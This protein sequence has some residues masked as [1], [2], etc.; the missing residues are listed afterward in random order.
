MAIINTTKVFNCMALILS[1]FASQA[2]ASSPAD[3][4]GFTIIKTFERATRT[5]RFHILPE[6]ELIGDLDRPTH[7]YPD[8]DFPNLM[9]FTPYNPN[10]GARNGEGIISCPLIM[11]FPGPVSKL[12]DS[13]IQQLKADKVQNTNVVVLFQDLPFHEA[14]Q[15]CFRPHG[16]VI[17]DAP[18]SQKGYDRKRQIRTGIFESEGGRVSFKGMPLNKTHM[19]HVHTH[20]ADG[21]NVF[22]PDNLHITGVDHLHPASF[23]TYTALREGKTT[24]AFVCLHMLMNDKQT[25]DLRASLSK[26][27]MKLVSENIHH[28]DKPSLLRCLTTTAQQPSFQGYNGLTRVL[29]MLTPA[30]PLLLDLA[31]PADQQPGARTLQ[32]IKRSLETKLTKAQLD[33]VPADFNPEVYLD[34]YWDVEFDAPRHE[35]DAFTFAVY[36]Y[37]M[38]GHSQGRI[39]ACQVSPNT[40]PKDFDSQRYLENY[41]DKLTGE[42][43]SFGIDD[44][45]LYAKLQYVNWGKGENRVYK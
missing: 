14:M 39:A 1:I 23:Y 3:T 37:A 40:A 5:N 38:W 15:L 18:A 19:D 30:A 22:S 41:W 31:G 9:F 24:K 8:A 11:R 28:S 17:P 27:D 35:M 32:D 6:N 20:A 10:E 4:E 42:A 13:I 21:G 43:K 36:Q 2:L 45:D 29:E 33:L 7:V 26:M 12:P 34:I 44:L 16:A 25:Q